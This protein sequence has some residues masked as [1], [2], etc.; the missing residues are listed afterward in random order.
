MGKSLVIVESKAKARTIS[1]YLGKDYTVMACMG[2]VRDLPK[3]TLGID[4]KDN[5]L[6]RYRIS[7]ERKEIVNDLKAA[8][9]K[10]DEVLLAT[11]PDREGEAI[12]WHLAFILAA[13]NVKRIEFN[14]ITK[15]AVKEA[16]E[17]ARDIDLNKVDAQQARRI[18]DRLVGYSLSPYLWREI[19]GGLSAGRVQSVALRLICERE[20]EIEKFV[21]QEYWTVEGLFQTKKSEQ[22]SAELLKIGDSKIEIASSDEVKKIESDLRE[23]GFAVD[24]I[25]V[26]SKKKNPSA[27]F[28]TSTLQ[29]V[30]STKLKYPP[31]KTMRIAQRLY[32]GVKVGSRQIG[33]ITYMRTDS[34][35]I[36]D[37]AMTE[38]RKH[39]GKVIGK[40]YLPENPIEYKSKKKI[41][42]AHEAI[43]PTDVDRTPESLKSELSSE[44]FALYDLIWRRYVASQMNPGVDNVTTAVIAGGKYEFRTSRTVQE[45]DGFRKIWNDNNSKSNSKPPLPEMSK[46]DPL[47]LVNIKPEQHFTEPPPRFSSASLIR[48]LE[49]LGIGRPSTYAP[50]VSIL[51]D[52]KY[53]D[54]EKGAFVPTI[55]GRKVDK[56]LLAKFPSILD[57]QYTAKMEDRLDLIQVG[58][59][60]WQEVVK[61]FYDPLY[62]SITKALN[63]DCP[64]CSKPLI[65]SSGPFGSYLACSNEECDYKKNLGEKEL[66]EKCPECGKPLIEKLGRFGR[67]IG[68]TG[69][70]D[71]KYIRKVPKSAEDG[72]EIKEIEY[73]KEPCPV[74]GNR[75]ILRRSRLGRF[76][77]C[78]KYPDCKGT[79]SF[80]IGFPCQKEG[81]DGELVERR[82]KRGKMFYSCSKYPDCD[83]VTFAHPLAGKGKKKPSEGRGYAVSASEQLEDVDIKDD[84]RE[85][86]VE[87]EEEQNEE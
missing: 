59:E 37:E 42:D 53:A 66:D 74:C 38:V 6:P 68:C 40:N 23:T 79:A 60:K 44:E 32:E 67:F 61:Q 5:F 20:E 30:A 18:L 62:E 64:K 76:Y 9:K 13:K 49:D 28:I 82:S 4:V 71:C 17:H 65:L 21:P 2:H 7:K 22:F 11:D 72:T 54:R 16:L 84:N 52:R 15:R 46:G 12:A 78:E 19:Q 34:F 43:R 83:F 26:M 1:Q 24:E 33:L 48:T 51:L 36:A 45:F 47:D 56:L 29:Q 8:S 25:K 70:P 35:R 10:A 80:K 85:E 39:I 55:L 50:T 41:Q 63:E 81:C 27:P 75:M 87:T 3:S 86:V 73:G 58:E 14:E 69:Y 57:Y 31:K 77:G